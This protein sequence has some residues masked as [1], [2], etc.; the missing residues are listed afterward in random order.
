MELVE[1][2]QVVEERLTRRVRAGRLAEVL[3][4]SVLRKLECL[5][6]SLGPHVHVHVCMDGEALRIHTSLPSVVPVATSIVLHLKNNNFG[7]GVPL[8]H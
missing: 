5:F 1:A 2:F 6:R 8:V 7:R 4:K 3:L